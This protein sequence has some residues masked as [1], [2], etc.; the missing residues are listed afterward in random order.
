[1]KRV[2]AALSLALVLVPT[3]T[4]AESPS[5]GEPSAGAPSRGEPSRGERSWSEIDWFEGA[6]GYSAAVSEAEASGASVLVYF[7][8]EW[9]PYCR[10]LNNGLL[11]DPVV[12]DQVGQMLAVRVNAEAGPEERSLAGHYQV[13]GYPALFVYTSAQGGRFASIRRTV[14][15]A[16]GATRM[17]TAEEFVESLRARLR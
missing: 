17:K 10:Q 1:M 6:A 11:S 4:G 8:T 7:Y 9:C 2:C 15:E 5:A 14:A 12:Q 16:S 13:R 3:L